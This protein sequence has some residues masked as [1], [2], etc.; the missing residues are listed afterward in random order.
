MNSEATPQ[1]VTTLYCFQGAETFYLTCVRRKDL[2]KLWLTPMLKRL[3]RITEYQLK[4]VNESDKSKSTAQPAF[5]TRSE[6]AVKNDN[7]T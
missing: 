1:S 3:L 6:V 5:T 7:D 2:R 4:S